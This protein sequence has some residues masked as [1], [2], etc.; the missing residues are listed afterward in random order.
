MKTITINASGIKIPAAFKTIVT[1]VINPDKDS[2]IVLDAMPQLE[3]SLGSESAVSLGLEKNS[4]V[5]IEPVKNSTDGS[6]T[7]SVGEKV[8]A[9]KPAAAAPS[10]RGSGAAT[11]MMLSNDDM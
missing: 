11:R 6:F 4:Q 8:Q 2:R 1:K 9:K 7:L 10:T 5:T 3:I